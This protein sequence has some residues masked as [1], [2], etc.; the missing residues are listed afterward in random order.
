MLESTFDTFL[1]D[2]IYARRARMRYVFIGVEVTVS[3]QLWLF[4]AY[5]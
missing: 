4:Y 5:F 2:N 1:V 3:I